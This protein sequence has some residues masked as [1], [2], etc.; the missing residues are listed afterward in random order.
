MKT[1]RHL[2][3]R[4]ITPV[5]A[6]QETVLTVYGSRAKAV[7]T[8]QSRRD[9]VADYITLATDPAGWHLWV[10]QLDADQKRGAV[11]L[12]GVEPGRD[13]AVWL[14]VRQLD[15]YHQ[16]ATPIDGL[17]ELLSAVADDYPASALTAHM[18]AALD[19]VM[20]LRAT[21]TADHRAEV[22]VR[23]IDR[24]VAS[25]LAP[26]IQAWRT[27]QQEASVLGEVPP[28]WV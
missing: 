7:E 3:L 21:A 17:A 20:D 27:G 18:A 8:A 16:P 15:R 22:D 10:Y 19:K 23:D 11:L 2:D 24:A 6:L 12:A 28:E 25:E 14:P 13:N 1:Y 26:F 5:S 4:H 9:L